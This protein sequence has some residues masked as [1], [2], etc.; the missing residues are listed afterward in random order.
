M[1][2]TFWLYLCA[3]FLTAN[4]A[5]ADTFQVA[6]SSGTITCGIVQSTWV[7]GKMSRGAF[8]AYSSQVKKLKVSARSARAPKKTKLLTK[9]KNL[10][11]AIAAGKES[12]ASGPPQGSSPT[13]TPS[14]LGNFDAQG[15]VTASGKA[16]FGIPASMSGNIGVGRAIYTAQCSCHG[17]MLNRSMPDYRSAISESPMFFSSSDVTDQML[18]DL[19]AYLNRYRQF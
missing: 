2:W 19:T 8:V 9:I 17:D 18:A 11:A 3:G 12:C 14:G 16:L 15:N 10:R 1:R 13:P 4:V 7:P 5:F 6:T